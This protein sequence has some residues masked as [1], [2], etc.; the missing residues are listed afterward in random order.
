MST[1]EMPQVPDFSGKVAS[2]TICDDD[3]NH[4]LVDPSFELQG[5]RLFVIG[6][7]PKGAT[8]SDWTVGVVCGVVCGVAW[9]RVTDYFLFDSL[10]ECQLA[11]E[12]SAEFHAD[13]D[14]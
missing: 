5:G 4:D 6:S 14:E 9:D 12:I 7:T 11:I 13:D 2:L 8:E 1:N 3:T 10:D